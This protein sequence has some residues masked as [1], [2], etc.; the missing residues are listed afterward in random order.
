MTTPTTTSRRP[1]AL[2][3][4]SEAI[5]ADLR[6]HDQWVLWQAEER[7]G[8][9]TKPL[10]QPDGT[11]ASSTDSSTWSTFEEA[12]AAY[13][14]GGFDGIGFVFSA[15]DPFFGLDLDHVRD[16]KTGKI[17]PVALERVRAFASYTE[18]S[19]SGTGLHVIGRGSLPGR[20]R[21]KGYTEIYDAGRY[22]TITGHL[23]A[24]SPTAVNDV[25]KLADLYAEIFPSDERHSAPA[26]NG[27]E[28][29]VSLSD[30]DLI[31]KAR[32]ARNGD[33]FARLWSGDWEGAGYP[34]QSEAD[35]ALCFHLGWWSGRD[36]AATDRLFRQSGLFR[37]KWD[38]PRGESTYGQDTVA[39]AIALLSSGYNPERP[40]ESP[41]EM[42]TVAEMQWP[43]VTPL[44]PSTGPAYPTSLMPAVLGDFV[45]SL[46]V[47]LQVPC[48]LIAA[49]VDAVIAAAVQGTFRVKLNAD[50]DEP[51]NAYIVAVMESGEKKTPAQRAAVAPIEEHERWLVDQAKLE[52]AH[53]QT[54]RDVLEARAKEAKASAAH[55]HDGQERTG[56]LK[57]AKSLNE[58]LVDFVVPTPPRLIA[59]D[60]TPEALAGLM[61]ENSDRMAIISSEG[62]IFNIL[63][64]RYSQNVPNLDLF[65]KSYTGEP[66][67]VDRKGRP[68]EYLKSAC[69]TLCLAIQPEVLRLIAKQPIFR[70]LGFLARI[71]FCLPES[72]VGYRNTQPPAVPVEVRDAY[73][74]VVTTLLNQPTGTD[75]IA[76]VLHLSEGAHRLFTEAQEALE[77][78]LAPGQD[79][80]N[81]RDWA[82]K[83]SGGIARRAARFHLAANA[84]ETHPE[85]VPISEDTM[86]AA[87]SVGDYYMAHTQVAFGL[88]GADSGSSDAEHLL[89][90]IS[91]KEYRAFRKQEA[92]QGNKGRFG[93][94]SRLD[95][96][97]SLLEDHGY[98]RQQA[99]PPRST[100]TP[101]RPPAPA[102]DIHPRLKDLNPYKPYN[103]PPTE[104]VRD[105]RDSRTKESADRSP[106]EDSVYEEPL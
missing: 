101:G 18:I 84:G 19:P 9:W 82:L 28:P 49:Q 64:G 38:S 1:S 25:A 97:L 48:D 17:D 57:E 50:W 102:Y 56:L 83:A 61:V 24:G 99:T 80:A 76:R 71:D 47:A 74:R 27:S 85:H 106:S 35:S 6:S 96:A 8:R 22:F 3:V 66:Y 69:L 62:G 58:Q 41:P 46:A 12:K 63:A 72:F 53:A 90:W 5:P 59:D 52:I 104:V 29:S 32:G 45:E 87:I 93:E 10:H 75:G 39:G 34:S 30:I 77:P 26:T 31:D 40:S 44:A 4:R 65:L 16:P 100:G 37:A 98:I 51:L 43:T 13:Q 78:R 86:R 89:A 94:V 20:R 103:P 54:E 36:A 14:T 7:D 11:Y 70:N 68:P 95:D 79:L 60:V 67:R 81:F 91:R 73:H 23:L 15:D 21:K 2:Q 105:S 33:K 42:A 55:S 92:W 88:M